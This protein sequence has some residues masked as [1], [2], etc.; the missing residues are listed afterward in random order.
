MH[1]EKKLTFC[2]SWQSIFT[3]IIVGIMYVTV[4]TLTFSIFFT[5]LQPIGMIVSI[6]LLIAPCLILIFLIHREQRQKV[7]LNARGVS[8]WQSKTLQK[9]LDYSNVQRIII[10]LEPRKVSMRKTTIIFDNGT[11]VERCPI[12]QKQTTSYVFMEYS[13]K[14]LNAIQRYTADK[15][16]ICEIKVV[17]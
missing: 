1:N 3:Y 15:L 9:Q 5:K 7:V 4:W 16:P 2:L 14:R 12:P 17:L 13:K 11:Y 10:L 6:F 8:Q